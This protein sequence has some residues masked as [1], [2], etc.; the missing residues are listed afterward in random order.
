M[1]V[2]IAAQC[3]LISGIDGLSFMNSLKMVQKPI[4]NLCLR[5]KPA[6]LTV[7]V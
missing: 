2:L 5:T 1:I 4:T 3:T 6:I 7:Q